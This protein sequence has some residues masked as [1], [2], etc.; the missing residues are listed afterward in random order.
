MCRCR[1]DV[2]IV[3]DGLLLCVA[4]LPTCVL[5]LNRERQS[6]RVKT[7]DSVMGDKSR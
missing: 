7:E 3:C 1:F 4:N 5:N 2:S 6:D